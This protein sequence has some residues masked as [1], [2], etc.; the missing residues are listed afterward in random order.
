[1]AF[2]PMVFIL[3]T[4]LEFLYNF[5]LSLLLV[6]SLRFVPFMRIEF[7]EEHCFFWKMRIYYLYAP[8]RTP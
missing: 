5:T 6:H 1:M 8:E 4:V 2:V 3:T 7:Y